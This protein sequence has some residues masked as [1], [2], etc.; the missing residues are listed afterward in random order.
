M[1]IDRKI[2]T[3]LGFPKAHYMQVERERRWLCRSVPRERVERSESITDLYVTG[4]RLRLREA[5]ALALDLHI[6]RLG[7][8]QGRR[9]LPVNLHRPHPIVAIPALRL[10]RE[11]V[12][13]SARLRPG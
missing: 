10:A 13:R 9:N 5:R 6:M 3:A 11:R 1:E 2:A 12:P 8:P 7:K 4:T